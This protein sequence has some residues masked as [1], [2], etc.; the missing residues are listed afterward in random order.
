MWGKVELAHKLPFD[1][2]VDDRTMFTK[3]G[4]FIWVAHAIGPDP[5]ATAPGIIDAYYD[6]LGAIEG[7]LGDGW[8][9]YHDQWRWMNDANLALR[10]FGGVRAAQLIDAAERRQFAADR[11]LDRSLF[12]AVHYEP[13]HARA[14][15]MEWMSGQ[16]KAFSRFA[17]LQR[18]KEDAEKFFGA[19]A[20]LMPY[21]K[22]LEGDA[23]WHYFSQCVK[24]EPW[25]AAMPSL[26]VDLKQ[27]DSATCGN[28][29]PR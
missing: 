22:L 10:D 9:V 18:F 27:S 14:G 2:M 19:L 6:K 11:A 26:S 7:A 21:V 12:I 17:M 4:G 15:L 25:P 24:Y 16:D 20:L 1:L 3:A 13:D 8:T 23:L 28:A 5:A 29:A